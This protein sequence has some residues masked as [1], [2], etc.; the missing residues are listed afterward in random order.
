MI[1]IRAC[2]GSSLAARFEVLVSPARPRTIVTANEALPSQGAGF[3]SIDLAF[4]TYP[5]IRRCAGGGG[6]SLRNAHRTNTCT[7]KLMY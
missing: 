3:L 4:N 2:E 1:R 5:A 6:L 7:T